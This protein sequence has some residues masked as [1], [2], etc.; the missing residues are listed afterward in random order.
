L[1]EPEGEGDHHAGDDAE[2]KQTVADLASSA[3]LRPI[4]AGPLRRAREL[5]GFQFLHMTLQQTLGTGWS[6]AIKILG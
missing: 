2:A 1:A 5:E 6:S 3:G 4:D